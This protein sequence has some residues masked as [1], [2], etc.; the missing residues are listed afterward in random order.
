MN[1]FIHLK[2]FLPLVTTNTFIQNGIILRIYLRNKF[3]Y[4]WYQF[5]T[6]TNELLVSAIS[7]T[8]CFRELG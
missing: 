2:M 3:P 4:K 8:C 7:F 6:L 5:K 1:Q